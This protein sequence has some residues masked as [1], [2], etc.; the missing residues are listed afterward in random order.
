MNFLNISSLNNINLEIN[1]IK[2]YYLEYINEEFS[3]NNILKIS[4]IH[5]KSISIQK[6]N[7]ISENIKQY[8]YE[9]DEYD[10]EI[11]SIKDE[12][13]ELLS[14]VNKK[15]NQSVIS[16][17]NE[18]LNMLS[19]LLD[20]SNNKL[21]EMS[22]KYSFKKIEELDEND[23]TYFNTKLVN[24]FF[25]TQLIKKEVEYLP[26]K[27]ERRNFLSSGYDVSQKPKIIFKNFYIFYYFEVFYEQRSFNLFFPTKEIAQESI[28]K[29]TNNSDNIVDIS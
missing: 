24:L 12:N 17:I 20:L 25:N 14:S 29:S 26:L 1:N 3:Q 11:N 22:T 6:N 15:F 2:D 9:I 23:K 10:K 19:K 16:E 18:R 4:T 28:N 7:N 27:L 21:K 8:L 5:Q 13:F